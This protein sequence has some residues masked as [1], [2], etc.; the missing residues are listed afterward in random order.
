MCGTLLVVVE[1]SITSCGRFALSPLTPSPSPAR[2]NGLYTSR[3]WLYLTRNCDVVHNSHI[4]QNAKAQ[5]PPPQLLR[6]FHPYRSELPTNPVVPPRDEGF[7]LAMC[8]DQCARGEGGKNERVSCLPHSSSLRPLPSALFPPPSL[9]K[10][11][12]H[13]RQEQ[14]GVHGAEQDVGAGAREGQHRY[15][16]GQH[17]QDRI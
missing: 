16:Q 10:D 15:H 6:D 11:Q 2:G 17:Q 8:R 3:F 14:E 1:M 12:H 9:L 7:R 4:S 13:V 5:E